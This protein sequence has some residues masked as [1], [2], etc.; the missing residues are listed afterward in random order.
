MKAFKFKALALASLLAATS[1]HALVAVEVAGITSKDGGRTFYLKQ[2]TPT[3]AMDTTE[4]IQVRNVSNGVVSASGSQVKGAIIV[5]FSSSEA[6]LKSQWNN[7]ISRSTEGALQIGRNVNGRIYVNG[8]YSFTQSGSAAWKLSTSNGHTITVS[9]WSEQ[10][11]W[12][13]PS[14]PCVPNTWTGF[15]D[16][17]TGYPEGAAGPCT[18]SNGTQGW[19][20]TTDVYKSLP[21]PPAGTPAPVTLTLKEYVPA[22]ISTT[23][24]TSI[25]SQITFANEDVG[26]QGQV[27]AA[28]LIDGRYYF[29]NPD[30]S[31][32]TQYRGE[33]TF[34]A[35]HTG[36][37]TSGSFVLW[38]A[39]TSEDRALMRQLGAKL[40][41][42]Y[43]TGADAPAA[44][45]DL[46]KADTRL[47]T[48]TQQIN[49]QRYVLAVDANQW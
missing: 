49:G 41:V 13:D 5:D 42:G 26:L 48:G 8:D 21:A 30:K 20:K 6:A 16:P 15:L 12:Q 17:A 39:L 25:S 9:G 14:A 1:A 27:F 40:F 3:T 47:P 18:L 11:W 35:L 45:A 4:I 37:L 36:A 29:I 31:T 24:S 23:A 19:Y 38:T 34:P 32:V 43:G 46:L 10:N 33:S 7:F 22:T 28:L 2:G 44:I